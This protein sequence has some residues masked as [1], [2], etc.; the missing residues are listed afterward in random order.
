MC[1][2]V[3]L[4]SNL[5]LQ[6]SS[7]SE[8]QP[9]YYLERVKPGKVVC[10]LFS[11]PYVYYV[12]SHEGCG[13]GFLK[14]GEV[15]EELELHQANYWALVKC[16]KEAQSRGANIELYA[17]WEGDQSLEP[18]AVEAFTPSTLG[19]PEFQFSE[20]HFINVKAYA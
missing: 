12:G 8:R 15:G 10:R 20:R 17:C 19:E 18:V 16:I 2:A 5:E 6:P 3:Y 14:D 11:L 7:W 9:G 13:C 4:A 1:L